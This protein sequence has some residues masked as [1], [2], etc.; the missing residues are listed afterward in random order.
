VCGV[1]HWGEMIYFVAVVAHFIFVV[2]VAGDTI[3]SLRWGEGGRCLISGGKDKKIMIW[4]T[5]AGRLR[6]TLEK[7]FGPVNA[8]RVFGESASSKHGG[9]GSI[10]SAGSS[11]RLGTGLSSVTSAPIGMG[12]AMGAGEFPA[13]ASA[14]RDQQ[15]NIW[16]NSGD[17]IS[18]QTAHKGSVTF[19]SEINYNVPVIQQQ[20]TGTAAA[21]VGV[22]STGMD[23]SST[24][25]GAA[26]GAGL[27][28]TPMM[29]SLGVDNVMKIWDLCRFRPVA[30]VTAPMNQGTLSKAVWCGNHFI[31][32]ST[33]GA[34]R[35]YEHTTAATGEGEWVGRDLAS[36]TLACADLLSTD[37][38]VA[39]ASKSGQILKW[40]V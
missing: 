17:C 11:N 18:S 21:A 38:F 10:A 33:S 39:S 40:E 6:V 3:S 16:T 9:L 28:L 20:R 25:S 8:L 5:R 24:A 4:D 13:F 32:G 1:C 2:V 31:T 35:M 12:A 19:L 34:V 27:V 7:H 36:H 14:G 22:S 29:A 23:G 15:M 30:E 26:G 37:S